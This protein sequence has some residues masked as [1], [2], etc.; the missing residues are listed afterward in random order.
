MYFSGKDINSIVIK[1][2][3]KKNIEVNPSLF[4]RL[5]DLHDDKEHSPGVLLDIP[6]LR[7]QNY[8]DKERSILSLVSQNDVS[9]FS[10]S[11]PFMPA[12]VYI[13][14][15]MMSAK[16]RELSTHEFKSN[17]IAPLDSSIKELKHNFLPSL[18]SYFYSPQGYT[19]NDKDDIKQYFYGN[20][21]GTIDRLYYAIYGHYH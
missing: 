2:P 9:V 17:Y 12:F 18:N 3:E 14:N 13:T 4:I 10:G 7:I 16:L 8:E 6:L 21:A 19:W 5:H 11:M 20:I 15:A 1:E